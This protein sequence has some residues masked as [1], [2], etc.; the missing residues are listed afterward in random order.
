M[1]E[2]I[3]TAVFG[4]DVSAGPRKVTQRMQ[5]SIR[6]CIENYINEAAQMVFANLESEVDADPEVDAD[7]DADAD[8]CVDV[9]AD[10]DD[11]A[12]VAARDEVNK[13]DIEQ[14][15]KKL[16]STHITRWNR[17]LTYEHHNKRETVFVAR[18]CTTSPKSFVR[19][20]ERSKWVTQML[21]D[22]N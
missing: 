16:L 21:P 14:T 19:E 11:N 8:A 12:N 17:T 15:L 13:H 5:R 10:T 22:I 18:P 2:N 6:R 7:A 20:A 4:H 1:T 3:I 9:E